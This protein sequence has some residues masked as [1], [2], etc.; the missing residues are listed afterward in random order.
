MGSRLDTSRSSI[1]ASADVVPSAI[2]VPL[3]GSDL[4]LRAAPIA[5]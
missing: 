3:D 5:S 4:S 2:V 1:S